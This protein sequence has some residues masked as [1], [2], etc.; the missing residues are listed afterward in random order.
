MCR[1]MWLLVEEGRGGSRAFSS[2]H[3][4]SEFRPGCSHWAVLPPSGHLCLRR[5]LRPK[6]SQFTRFLTVPRHLKTLLLVTAK[7]EASEQCLSR[8][9]T[10]VIKAQ[11]SPCGLLLWFWRIS[12]LLSWVAPQV[13]WIPHLLFLD[14]FQHFGGSSPP[15][16]FCERMHGQQ[17]FETLHVREVFF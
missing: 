16:A 5:S 15:A 13:P 3:G 1:G 8:A 12:L 10:P 7:Q 9:V 17:R 4:K 11:L 14:F 2:L 6:L